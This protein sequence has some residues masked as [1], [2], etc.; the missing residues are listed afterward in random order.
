MEV[1]ALTDGIPLEVLSQI[2]LLLGRAT[3]EARSESSSVMLSTTEA[4]KMLR[5][6]SEYVRDIIAVGEL[7]AC[8]F[9]RVWRIRSSDLE[10]FVLKHSTSVVAYP[11]Q[12]PLAERGVARGKDQSA[13]WTPRSRLARRKR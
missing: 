2:A 13:S 9:G 6:S 10:T 4:A 7:P 5:V 8:R 11:N 3:R 12:I 1:R